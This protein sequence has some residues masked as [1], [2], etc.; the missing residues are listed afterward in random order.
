MIFSKLQHHRNIKCHNHDYCHFLGRKALPETLCSGASR[1]SVGWQIAWFSSL[2]CSEFQYKKV[3]FIILAL[4]LSPLQLGAGSCCSS[5]WITNCTEQKHKESKG[6]SKAQ[7][8]LNSRVDFGVSGVWC[9]HFIFFYFFFS[10]LGFELR[11]SCLLGKYSTTWATPPD[12][13]FCWVFSF[14][15]FYSFIHMCIHCLG[16]ISPLPP[17]S[18]SP[19]FQAEP[20]LPLSLILLKRRHKQ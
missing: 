8:F 16:H 20:G 19:H 5:D 17:T 15:I 9:C 14:F 11:A 13:F 10:T 18:T 4:L 7:S 12:F 2:L 1:Q 6:I 3:T